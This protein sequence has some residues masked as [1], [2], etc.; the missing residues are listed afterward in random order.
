MKFSFTN[1]SFPLPLPKQTKKRIILWNLE[2]KFAYGW[3]RR[4]TTTIPNCIQQLE[5]HCFPKFAVVENREITGVAVAG[6]E[7]GNSSNFS[8]KQKLPLVDYY[9]GFN[10]LL[11]GFFS[12]VFELKD[13]M[14]EKRTVFHIGTFN[15][16][17][18]H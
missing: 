13:E 1:I 2:N 8:Y 17:M 3:K 11:F 9:G 5:K 14:K 12:K 6:R 4:I 10:V 15:K 7:R 16:E 18:E